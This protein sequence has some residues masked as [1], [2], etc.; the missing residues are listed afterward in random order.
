MVLRHDRMEHMQTTDT[1][2]SRVENR[3]QR[4]NLAGNSCQTLQDNN[5]STRNKSS[6]VMSNMKPLTA[7]HSG[8]F[9]TSNLDDDDDCVDGLGRGLGVD[10]IG[11]DDVVNNRNDMDIVCTTSPK[12]PGNGY[13]FDDACHT[14]PSRYEFGKPSFTGAIPAEFDSSLS[15]LFACMSIAYR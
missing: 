3:S 4:V 10:G 13:N 9:M 5:K 2:A 12:T 8:H 1:G 15:K 6:T 14:P 7:T 11:V